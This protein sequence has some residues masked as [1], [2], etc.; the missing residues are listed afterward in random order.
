MTLA[1]VM[2]ALAVFSAALLGVLGMALFANKTAQRA[3]YINVADQAAQGVVEQLRGIAYSPVSGVTLN[4][5]LNQSMAVSRSV[6]LSS[7][8]TC[9]LARRVPDTAASQGIALDVLYRYRIPSGGLTTSVQRTFIT[10]AG[11]Q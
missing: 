4:L 3:T 8:E 7:F 11:S 10:N 5:A 2:I 1:E 9:I 6:D